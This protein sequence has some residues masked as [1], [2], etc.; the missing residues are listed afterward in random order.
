MLHPGQKEFPFF[1]IM[2]NEDGKTGSNSSNAPSSAQDSI[3]SRKL[4]KILDSDL[5]GDP[6]LS[7]ALSELS[8]FFPE[9]TLRTR[10][11]LRGDIERRSLQVGFN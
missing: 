2:S 7:A 1:Y 9:N 10:R 4:K 5:E 8:T 6:D 11:F 3:L